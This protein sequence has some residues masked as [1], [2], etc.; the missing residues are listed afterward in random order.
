MLLLIF[1]MIKGI[2]L[3][4]ISTVFFSVMITYFREGT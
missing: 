3:F 2:S 4:D 1:D